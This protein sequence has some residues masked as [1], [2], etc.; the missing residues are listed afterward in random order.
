MITR[1]FGSVVFPGGMQTQP[2]YGGAPAVDPASWS[3]TGE[4][5]LPAGAIQRQ[6]IRRPSGM[7]RNGLG[8]AAVTARDSLC[9]CLPVYVGG[10]YDYYDPRSH[11]GRGR[12]Q[13]QQPNITV[14]YPPQQHAQARMIQPGPEANT[15]PR[16]AAAPASTKRRAPE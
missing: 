14:I 1:N 5:R 4:P 13:Q 15:T 8:T 2:V 10:G 16:A 7:D 3:R 11:T 12:P 6:N 9:V